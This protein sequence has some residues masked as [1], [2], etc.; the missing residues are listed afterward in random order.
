[1][2][3][4]LLSHLRW[5]LECR[6]EGCGGGEVLGL[7]EGSRCAQLCDDE[8]THWPSVRASLEYRTNGWLQRQ[9]VDTVYLSQAVRYI[10][11]TTGNVVGFSAVSVR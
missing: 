1:M 11:Q 8:Y 6:G 4:K 7:R 5:E 9:W 10:D 2:V 3:E